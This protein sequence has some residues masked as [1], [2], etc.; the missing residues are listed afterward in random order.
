MTSMG[1]IKV[2][3]PHLRL[4]EWPF[5][6]TPDHNFYT[7][8]ADRVQVKEDLGGILKSLSR[9]NTSTIHLIWSWYGAGKTHTLR[10]MEYMCRNEYTG[11]L[12]IYTEIPRSL[13]NFCDIYRSFAAEL[14]FELARNSFLEVATSPLKDALEKELRTASLDMF[15][16]FKMLCMGTDQ[17]QDVILRWLR[18]EPLSLSEIRPLGIGKRITTAEDAIRAVS[19]IVRLFNAGASL[20][21]GET[22]R[23]V[24]M[25]DEFQQVGQSKPVARE[26]NNCLHSIFNRC[27][28]SLSLFISFSG[29]P[30]KNYPAWLSPELADRI[31]VQKVVLLPPLTRSEAKGFVRD[32]LD[33]F[34]P[35]GYSVE[36]LGF[37]PFQEGT[38]DFLLELIEKDRREIRPRNLMQYFTSVLEVAEPLLEKGELEDIG[39]ALARE[40]LKGRLL[41]EPAQ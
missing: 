8:M 22:R 23:V 17:Q 16:A 27:P 5:Q 26:V 31:G 25:I 9:R 20:S 14:D 2:K 21:E 30:E 39:E 35:P 33:H 15:N 4:I 10:H 34:R 1:G 40:C 24:W 29:K 37:F 36:D 32:V 18:G 38:V 11:L 7:F 28:N 3:Y 6:T 13:R 41:E 12:P 19:W